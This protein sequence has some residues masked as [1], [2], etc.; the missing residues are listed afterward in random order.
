VFVTSA[1]S[2]CKSRLLFL[3]CLLES[4]PQKKQKKVR[5]ADEPEHVSAT[6]KNLLHSQYV[7]STLLCCCSESQSKKKRKLSEDDKVMASPLIFPE[8]FS[9]QVDKNVEFPLKRVELGNHFLCNCCSLMVTSLLGVS[10]ETLPPSPQLSSA[11]I[12]PGKHVDLA[13]F[14]NK[15]EFVTCVY[16]DGRSVYRNV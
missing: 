15:Y 12:V 1:Y 6:G 10:T 11:Q 13:I 14:L 3:L 5:F 2:I 7:L 9:T 8:V 16:R 4:Q